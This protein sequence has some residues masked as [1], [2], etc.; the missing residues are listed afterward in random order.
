[1]QA[2][3]AATSSAIPSDGDRACHRTATLAA[4]YGGL[5]GSDL[6]RPLIEREFAGRWAGSEKTGCGIHW[7]ADQGLEGGRCSS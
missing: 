6:L 5:D 1:M 4:R 2:P 7:L 3:P